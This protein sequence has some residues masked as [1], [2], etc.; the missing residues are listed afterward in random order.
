MVETIVGHSISTREAPR[1]AGDPPALVARASRIRETL[2]WIP[3]H[4]DLAKIVGSSLEW[5]R[6]LAAGHW[7]S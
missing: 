1:R 2:G 6:K 5:E 4:D 3:H 7:S